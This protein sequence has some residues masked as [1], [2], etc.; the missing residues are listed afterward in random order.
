MGR[1]FQADGDG[2][3]VGIDQDEREVL[4]HLLD[5]VADLLDPGTPDPGPVDPLA[6]ALGLDPAELPG[7]GVEGSGAASPP[8]A[9]PEDPAVARLLPQGHRE[10]PAEAEEFR[11][12]TEHGLRARKRSSLRLA[13]A[14]LRG[15]EPP[16]LTA[17]Q[18]QALVKGLTDLRL[19]LGERLGLRTDED[20]ERLQALVHARSDPD[21]PF[22]GLAALYDHLTWWQEYLVAALMPPRG[23]FARRGGRRG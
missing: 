5:Q 18:A 19:V 14:A 21:D 4:A 11:R 17:E 13:G 15:P 2:I 12:L 9:E 22:V 20:T 7:S 16:L 10:D 3:R 23:R 6:E 1:P 8:V